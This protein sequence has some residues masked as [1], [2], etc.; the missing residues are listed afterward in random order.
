MINVN[1]YTFFQRICTHHLLIVQHALLPANKI[2][3]L[4]WRSSLLKLYTSPPNQLPDSLE[5]LLNLPFIICVYL[6]SF[7]V[8]LKSRTLLNIYT[9]ENTLYQMPRQWK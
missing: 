9:Y 2:Y 8:N 6:C 4:H 7:V 1:D 5:K 3:K